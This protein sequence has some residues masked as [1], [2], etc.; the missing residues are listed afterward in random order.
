MSFVCLLDRMRFE[1]LP[2]EL[3]LDIFSYFYPADLYRIVL[4]LQHSR[5]SRLLTQVRVSLD[6]TD[7]S[8][9]QCSLIAQHCS[10]SQI[11]FLRLTN[12]YSHG[13]LI[14]EFFS[15]EHFRPYNFSRLHSLHLDDVIGNELDSL[16]ENLQKLNVK[17]H[18][19]AQF[20]SQ[21]YRLALSSNSLKECYLIGGY[22]FDQQTC[23]PIFSSTIERLHMAMKSFPTDLVVVLQSLPSLVKLKSKTIDRLARSISVALTSTFSSNFTIS[24]V[25]R[26]R[27][28]ALGRGPYVS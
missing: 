9:S 8:L 17:F 12:Q 18:K 14:R 28:Q 4:P 3:L 20:A 11:V 13:L 15:R 21:F 26:P 16:P 1:D 6:L 24:P 25:S 7:T 22:A 27:C 10:S 23:F 2:S 19:K 5:F